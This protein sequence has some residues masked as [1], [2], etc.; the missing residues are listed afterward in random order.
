MLRCVPVKAGPEALKPIA[1][2]PAWTDHSA[3]GARCGTGFRGSTL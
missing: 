3:E 1:R 2:M